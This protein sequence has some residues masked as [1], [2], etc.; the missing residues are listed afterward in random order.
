LIDKVPLNGFIVLIPGSKKHGTIQGTYGFA[1]VGK[2]V[3]QMGSLERVSWLF[4]G[5]ANLPFLPVAM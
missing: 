1:M 4:T 5:A 2:H 3:F